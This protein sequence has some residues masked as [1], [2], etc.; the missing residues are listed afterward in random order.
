[1]NDE[2]FDQMIRGI[3]LLDAQLQISNDI[4]YNAAY[5]NLRNISW[6]TDP[7]RACDLVEAFSEFIKSGGY[8]GADFDKS[9]MP[10]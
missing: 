9:K 2:Q 10:D 8:S 5:K 3:S 7:T 4:A 1:M 6:G